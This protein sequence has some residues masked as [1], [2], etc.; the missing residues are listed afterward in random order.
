MTR[1]E[2]A[3]KPKRIRVMANPHLE[4]KGKT[5][6]VACGDVP[7]PTRR[8][9]WLAVGFYENS[10]GAATAFAKLNVYDG[11]AMFDMSNPLLVFV[12]P[13]GTTVRCK[14]DETKLLS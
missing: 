5:W 1:E 8:C 13:D 12:A 3:A 14:A 10:F 7:K 4:M 9:E 6:V 11:R 2:L